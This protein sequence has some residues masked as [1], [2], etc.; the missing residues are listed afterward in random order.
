[1]T[2]LPTSTFLNGISLIGWVL[3]TLGLGASTLLLLLELIGVQQRPY[4]GILTFIVFPGILL[5]GLL[6]IP[7]GA[8][9]HR[10]RMRKSGE[11]LPKH[12]VLDFNQPRLR[13]LVLGFVA[14]TLIILLLSILGGY[15]AYEFTESVTFCGELCH[16]VME[17]E[18][19]AYQDSPH[20][21]VKCVECHVGPG[22]GWYLRAKLSGVEQVYGVLTGDHARPIPAPVH[23]MRTAQ[24]TCTECHWPD[25]SFGEQAFLR[26][27]FAHDLLSTRREFLVLMKTGGAMDRSGRGDGSHWHANVNNVVEYVARDEQ[28][29]QIPWIRVQ[30][31]GA[32]T[33]EYVDPERPPTP[34]ELATLEHR[35]M[36]CVD[37][38]NRPAH[39]FHSPVT[40]V[41][42][43]LEAGS[44]DG[45]LPHAKDAAVAVLA[46]AAADFQQTDAS[47]FEARLKAHYAEKYPAALAEASPRLQQAAAELE[48][49]Y[50]RNVF[51]GMKA[52]WAAYP[53]HSGHRE[54][55]GCLRCHDGK[56]VSA[57]GEVLSG[58]C[59]FCHTFAERSVD[60]QTLAMLPADGSF[61]HPW[62][63]TKHSEM[64]CSTCHTGKSSPYE[65]C[66][67]CHDA[68]PG[69]VMA[70]LACSSC[71]RPMKVTA[72]K[73]DCLPCHNTAGSKLHA[74]AGHADCILCHKQHEWKTVD[75]P[76]DC[77][78]ACHLDLKEP[79]HPGKACVPCHVF[80]GVPSIVA[81]AGGLPNAMKN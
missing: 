27:R 62:K 79:H 50:R 72:D 53:D 22:A 49:I 66:G 5:L 28:R 29:T 70:S 63:H 46:A 8:V 52:S 38:H 25:K 48:R 9:L 77:T 16:S 14:T 60:G 20:A 18:Y 45:K 61:L 44:L 58:A 2:R 37:C 54:S 31:P 71:H 35:R 1:M 81:P 51:P 24:E 76:D 33:V 57:D 39:D 7:L 42:Q 34:E 67:R 11:S 75:Y 73:N 30:V 40:A 17:P 32:G 26:V 21:R 59:D 43:A 56:H 64:A 23:S 47:W 10:R 80:K 4:T 74:T 3:A 69:A 19:V 65:G 15:Q 36:E 6:L 68:E 55:P 41:D 12:I 78:G 13:R